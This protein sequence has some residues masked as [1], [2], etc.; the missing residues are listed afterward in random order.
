MS[1]LKLSTLPKTW[2]IDLD[3][4]VF[5]HN[6]FL[7]N[8]EEK[9]LPG[10]RDLFNKISSDDYVIIT[11]SR[12]EKLR[13]VTEWNLNKSGMRYNLLL[14]ELP[15]GERVLINDKKPSGLK[16][17]FAVNVTRD[18]GMGALRIYYETD[19]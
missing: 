5:Q 8:E 18:K 3:G 7:T 6:G 2:I 14:M 15:K 12:S 17:A 19:L 16:T 10:V 4:T 11:T 13:Q 9:P 1:T